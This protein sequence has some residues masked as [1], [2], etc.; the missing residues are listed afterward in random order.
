[1]HLSLIHI[2]C[3]HCNTSISD[4]EVEYEEKDNMAAVEVGIA[5][6]LAVDGN[7]GITQHGLGAGGCQLQ[8]V[9][10]RQRK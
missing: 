1:M 5:G 2:W 4:A 7:S 3:P 9:Y 10:K 8:D 6:V